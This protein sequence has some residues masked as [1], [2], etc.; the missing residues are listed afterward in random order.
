MRKKTE[1]YFL[2]MYRYFYSD[3]LPS[4]HSDTEE[5]ALEEKCLEIDQARTAKNLPIF[6]LGTQKIILSAFAG[7]SNGLKR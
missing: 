3:I 5:K 7:A 2:K 4:G 1:N 6:S